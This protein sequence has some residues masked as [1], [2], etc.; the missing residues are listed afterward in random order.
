[1]TFIDADEHTIYVK[2]RTRS[3]RV[4]ASD[5][6]QPSTGLQLGDRLVV[7]GFTA[8][9]GFGPIVSHA[10]FDSVEPGAVPEPRVA[11]TTSL[12]VGRHESDCDGWRGA[13]TADR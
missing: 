9:G 8:A 6:A 3:I 13:Q 5:P 1:V 10:T 7:S 12:I 11:T 2:G 4:V